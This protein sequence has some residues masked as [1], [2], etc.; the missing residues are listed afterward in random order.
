MQAALCTMPPSVAAKKPLLR[1]PGAPTILEMERQPKRRLYTRVPIPVAEQIE[2]LAAE[3]DR[4]V[5]DFLR[6]DLTRRYG[7]MAEA[8]TRRPPPRRA[9]KEA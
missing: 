4:S 8:M 7:G 3:E 5:M 9:R 2:R 1:T 6:R